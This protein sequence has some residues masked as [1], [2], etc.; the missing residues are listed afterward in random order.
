[1]NPEIQ[2]L[3]EKSRAQERAGDLAQATQLAEQALEMARASGDRAGTCGGLT[4]LAVIHARQ[5]HCDEASRLASQ[6]L[7]FA[8]RT[9]ESVRAYIVLGGCA[10]E[11]YDF[12]KAE[13]LFRRCAEL[14][15][16]IGFQEGLLLALH[17]LAEDV[18]MQRGHFTLALETEQEA[19]RI[20]LEIQSPVNIG[21][22]MTRAY[23][24]QI[25][26]RRA[27]AR[28]ALAQLQEFPHWRAQAVFMIVSARLALD[29]EDLA[30]AA[31]LL[32]QARAIAERIGHPL[33]D[34]WLRGTLSRL[35]RLQGD[36]AAARAWADDALAIARRAGHLLLEGEALIVRAEASRVLDDL[37]AVETDL[38][39]A[40]AVT[41]PLG[42]AYH[43]A[44]ATLLQAALY[45]QQQ[46]PEAEAV[47]LDA[48]Q[49]IA[50]GGY[51][52]L[53]EREQAFAFPLV[54]HYVHSPTQAVRAASEKLLD[55]L[56]RVP[57]LPLHVLGLGRFQIQQGN[58]F[59]PERVWE[60]RRAGEML[61]FLLLQ[62]RYTAP[63]EAVFEALW[64]NRPP[65]SAAALFHQATSTLRR[66]LEP[67]LPVKF[68]SR[69]LLVED[70]HVTLRLPSGS[71]MDADE[72]ENQLTRAL[73]TETVGPL[74]RALDQYSGELF[75][76]DR[77]SAWSAARREHLA[78]F[79]LRGLQVLARLY[80]AANRPHEALDVC[81]RIVGREPWLE[82]AVWIGMRACLALNDRPGA[83]RL[84]RTLET[85]LRQELGIS[86]RDDL[87]S[88]AQSL[89]T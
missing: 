65:A 6:A 82:E 55:R 62:P 75:P 58:R 14:S 87:Q 59:L 11:T 57:P 7:T 17:N 56:S 9:P 15:R 79:E 22:A 70:E 33:T 73:A 13:Q 54:T 61:R 25:M 74:I 34:G 60:R 84:Y 4:H 89:K 43:A 24:F 26:G 86:P 47:W 3:L 31:D 21:L 1:M 71:T 48:A 78:Q 38:K 64:P 18:Y 35:Y 51:E 19:H 16:Q 42:A 23:L 5:G 41:T 12:A 85:N 40:L 46:R 49:R 66:V 28:E 76:L 10:A 37:V 67:D 20:G 77:Y 44:L 50:F 80:L 32:R 2:Q 8:D 69:Y 30:A 83:L 72:F 53:L 36:G 27:E 45:F 63:R 81:R 39:A 88:L 68:P 29:E 52:F